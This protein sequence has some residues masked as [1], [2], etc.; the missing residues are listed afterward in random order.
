[1]LSSCSWMINLRGGVDC[2]LHIRNITIMESPW[3]E[4]IKKCTK[5]ETLI[6]TGLKEKAH[7]FKEEEGIVHVGGKMYIPPDD[8][9]RQDLMFEHHD[10]PTGGHP[11][12]Y[13]MYELLN[14][15]YWWP[16]M[17]NDVRKYVNGCESCQRNKI[18]RQKKHAPLHPHDIPQHP[19]EHIGIDMI[20]PLP[21][22]EIGRAHV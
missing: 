5:R 19:W 9:L 2:P 7:W 18:R 20:G 3:T 8:R 14:R 21:E 22:S 12:H 11:G 15:S 16:T 13:R 1:M 4:R 17:L 10:T 6:T